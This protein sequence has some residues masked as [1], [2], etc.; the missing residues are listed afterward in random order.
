M[1]SLLSGEQGAAAGRA[2]SAVQSQHYTTVQCSAVTGAV[3]RSGLRRRGGAEA[4]AGRE[5]PEVGRDRERHERLDGRDYSGRF[6]PTD[7]TSD[8]P[9]RVDLNSVCAVQSDGDQT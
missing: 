5:H 1:L 3:Q 9:E 7:P 4:A 8:A 2:D 6:S